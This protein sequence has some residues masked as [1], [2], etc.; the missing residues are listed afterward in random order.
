V[1]IQ[2]DLSSR[3]FFD[4]DRQHTYPLIGLSNANSWLNIKL[5]RKVIDQTA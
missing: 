5:Q 4:D 3:V 2:T 1:T